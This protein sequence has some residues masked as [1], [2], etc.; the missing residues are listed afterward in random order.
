MW[1]CAAGEH[2]ALAIGCWHTHDHAAAL[3]SASS[4]LQQQMSCLLVQSLL[5]T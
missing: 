4:F 3:I 2:A 1:T 5:A